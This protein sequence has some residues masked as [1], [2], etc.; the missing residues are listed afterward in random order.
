MALID[1]QPGVRICRNE[2]ASALF[3]CP[4]EV[5]KSLMQSGIGFPD[6]IVL[7]DTIYR[8]SVLQNC[9]EFPLYYFLFVLGNLAA[10]KRLA[11]V[12]ER[13]AVAANREL[14][15]LTLLGPT[16]EE[17]AALGES[18]HFDTLYKEARYLSVKD[19]SGSELPIE[20][21]VDFV[22]FEG[23]EARREA[24][25]IR[26]LGSDLY[27]MGGEEI[28]LRDEGEQA[29]VYD[30]K[31]DYAP[32]IPQKFGVDILGGGSG[33]TPN[34]PSSAVLLGYNS[35]Y[36][37]ID[38]P[39]YLDHHLAARGIAREQIKSVF[40]THIHDDHCNPF[41]LITF[42]T[43]LE[44]LGTPEIYWMTLR[45]LSLQTMRPM[46]ELESYFDFVPLEPYAENDFYGIKI[47]PHYTVH[48]IP[49]IG[50][51]F[52][53]DGAGK[54]R[55]IV[56]GGDN[57][58]LPQID[59]MVE[60][61]VTPA[62]KRDYI[63]RLYTERHDLMM[64]DGGMGLLHGDPEDSI[65][66][67]SDRVVFMHLE[68]L[69]EKFDAAFAIALPGKRYILSESRND[70]YLIKALEI[71]HRDFPGISEAWA[72]ALM[73]SVDIVQLNSGD[74]VIKQG[75]A[76]KGRIYLI[77]SGKCAVLH[78][79]GQRLRELATKEAG[80]FIGEMAVIR[81]EESRSA[82]V[83]AKTPVILGTIDED[84]YYSFLR[85]EGRI[86][87]IERMW[88]IRTAIE[89][90]PPFSGFDDIVNERLARS[91]QLVELEAGQETAKGS[92]IIV[93]SGRLEAR[94]GG[95]SGAAMELGPGSFLG[96]VEGRPALSRV[97]SAV[98][99]T[100]AS[101]LSLE[102]ADMAAVLDRTPSLLFELTR[103]AESARG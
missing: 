96:E 8:G 77:L 26:R 90:V 12:G 21:F 41:P 64:V 48:S 89:A 58:A 55:S 30:L 75:E 37:L 18:P 91:G 40:L 20:G 98:A 16:L 31:T 78:H 6:A 54:R 42:N 5:I 38:C 7:P 44:L 61:G 17:Y 34:K 25:T 15:R 95:K 74:I 19:A 99:K 82:S 83:I 1:I 88:E 29:P 62:D 97:R 50:A 32:K 36:M 46:E 72:T 66:S 3:G 57:K 23:G 103:L 68:K 49:T 35:D 79:D 43:R 70:A 10:G 87:A 93:L 101:A 45:K 11:I 28:S 47:V 33:F 69:P 100:S 59:R 65:A 67:K 14:L 71:F 80:D 24:W 92:F 73:S 51:T 76:R 56:F 52:S 39:P 22:P 63:R 27:E 86:A 102:S 94:S 60:L 9:T 85:A 81:R 2:E 13:A 84:I 4:P 53:M